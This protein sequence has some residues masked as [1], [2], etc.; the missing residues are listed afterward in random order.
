MKWRDLQ[1]NWGLSSIKLNMKFAE[2][3]FTPNPDDE[4]AA[5]VYI[6]YLK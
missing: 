1:E 2:L 6:R 4:I 3:E 5:I